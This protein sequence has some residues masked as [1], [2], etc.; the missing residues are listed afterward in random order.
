MI[1]KRK[2][3]QTD[4]YEF[5]IDIDPEAVDIEV[6]FI[7]G[8][9]ASVKHP[10]KNLTENRVYWQIMSAVHDEICK[11]EAGYGVHQQRE[12]TA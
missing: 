11:V 5:R 1:N 3:T 7:D 12:E 9:Y 6:T 4:V 2:R 8:K 10:F